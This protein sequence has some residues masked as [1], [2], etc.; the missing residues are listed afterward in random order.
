MS[1]ERPPRTA[2]RRDP[3]GRRRA[4]AAAAQEVIADVGIGRTT[5]RAVAERA[6]VPL[7]ATTYYFP[8]LTDLVAAALERAHTDLGVELRRWA[9][10]LGDGTDLPARLT[11]LI[12]EY[13]DDRSQALT[14]FELYLAAARSPELRVLAASWVDQVRE[15]LAPLVGAG[16]A[17]ALAVFLD[18]VALQHLATGEPVDP[19]AIE[20]A[21]AALVDA[22]PGN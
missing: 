8:T 5:H 22:D 12:C 7:G 16:A 9:D 1:T 15:V 3:E 13:L 17:R 21:L 10:H 14:E 19:T 11:G 2:R 6:D 4:L 20:T 18:G